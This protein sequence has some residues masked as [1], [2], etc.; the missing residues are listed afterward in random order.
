MITNKI[1]D[2]KGNLVE[3]T[4]VDNRHTIHQ[5]KMAEGWWNI[6]ITQTPKHLRTH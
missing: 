3:R 6:S 4:V 5:V 2:S 1:Y